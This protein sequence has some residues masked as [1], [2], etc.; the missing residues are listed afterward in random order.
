VTTGVGSLLVTGYC[1]VVHG[2]EVQEALNIAAFATVLGMVSMRAV[3]RRSPLHT[4]TVAHECTHM[5]CSEPLYDGA[6]M[7]IYV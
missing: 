7:C 1:V 4:A 6:G 2:Q 3:G 5:H